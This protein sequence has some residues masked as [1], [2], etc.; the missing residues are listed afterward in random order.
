MKVSGQGDELAV[1]IRVNSLGCPLGRKLGEPQNPP[2]HSGEEKT[3]C[4][5]QELNFDSFI[6]HSAIQSQY[7]RTYS[8][9]QSPS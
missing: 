6:V 5:H 3:V 1:F 7:V 8:M 4:P 9:E 2:L